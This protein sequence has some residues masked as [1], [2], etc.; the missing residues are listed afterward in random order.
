MIIS[1][2]IIGITSQLVVSRPATA[3]DVRGR[4]TTLLAGTSEPR[5]GRGVKLGSVY[6]ILAFEL[7][8]IELPGFDTSRLVLQGW[9]ALHFSEDDYDEHG[10]DLQ[11]L[12]LDGRTGPLLLRLGRQHISRGVARMTLLDGLD[13]EVQTSFGLRAQAYAGLLVNPQFAYESSDWQIGGRVAYGFDAPGEVGISYAQQRRRGRLSRDE[14]GADAYALLG[15]TRWTGFAALNLAEM[16]LAEAR[17][18]SSL[19]VNSDFAIDVGWSLTRG[20]LLIPRTS[21]FSVFTD[22]GHNR[23]SAHVGWEPDPYWGVDASFD[24]LLR[25]GE[26]LGHD[27]SLRGTTYREPTHR[28]RIGL[29]LRQ[30]KEDENGFVMARALTMLQVSDALRI[31]GDLYGYLYDEAI[32][33]SDGS[34]L[35]HVSLGYDFSPAVRLVGTASAGSSPYASYELEGMIRF[36]YGYQVDLSREYGP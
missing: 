35:G 24:A 19:F 2:L 18:N 32:N 10:A 16:D 26:W 13:A 11:L 36:A 14:L 25:D 8:N 6:E 17:L 12:Y 33:G 20:D 34:V 21:I 22:I 1:F 5:G 4:F 29:E 27:V 7:G 28:S 3:A 9:G 31:G 23:I 15:P 30:L